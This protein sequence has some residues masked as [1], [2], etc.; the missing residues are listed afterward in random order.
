MAQ[1]EKPG[2]NDAVAFSF[3]PAGGFSDPSYNKTVDCPPSG[4]DANCQGDKYE[5]C[6]LHTLC[7]GQSRENQETAHSAVRDTLSGLQQAPV[8]W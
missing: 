6:I 4:S 7:G 8:L 3:Y 2:V 5:A 1:L